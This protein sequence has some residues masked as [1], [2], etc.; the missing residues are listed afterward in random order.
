MYD[1]E[2]LKPSNT[3]KLIADLIPETYAFLWSRTVIEQE[4][5]DIIKDEKWI[6]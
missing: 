6:T 3:G 2:V 4:I 1:T 5:V